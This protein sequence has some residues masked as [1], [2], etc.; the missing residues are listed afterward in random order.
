MISAT[1]F[2]TLITH[3][4]LAGDPYLESDA[5]FAVKPSLI[6]QPE[7]NGGVL[8]IQYDFSLASD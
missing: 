8:I 7:M 4:F 3:L 1:G 6:V 5:V 2:R